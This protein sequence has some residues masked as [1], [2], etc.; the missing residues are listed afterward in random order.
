MCLK[1]HNARN[2]EVVNIKREKISPANFWNSLV[3]DQI[4]ISQSEFFKVAIFNISVTYN[5]GI[6]VNF[7]SNY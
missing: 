4:A 7:K 3:V 6:K 5:H 2:F 1:F